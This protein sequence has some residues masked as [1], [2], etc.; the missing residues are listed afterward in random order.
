MT[1]NKYGCEN[2]RWDLSALYSSINCPELEAD[3]KTCES[4][5][6][7]IS[8]TCRGKVSELD[9]NGLYELI[10]RMENVSERLGKINSFAEL[11]FATQVT[12]PEAGA[13]LQKI[14]EFSSSVSRELLFF[15][16]EWT[17]VPDPQA[18]ALISDSRLARYRHFLSSLRRYK[19]HLLT[20]AE[21]RI[22]VEFNPVGTDS[23][24][25][26]FE[27]LLADQR[28]GQNG[29]TQEELLSDLYNPA[30]EIR[31][32]AAS[33]L[34]NGLKANGLVLTHVFNT[35]LATKMIDDRL[36]QYP[37]W[38][39]S[40]NLHNE[41]EDSI[42]NTLTETVIS[43]YDMVKRYY[44]L[45]QKLLGLDR[46]YDYDRYAPVKGLPT[47]KIDWLTCKEQV[48][49]AFG[50]FSGEMSGIAAHF[51]DENWIDAPV[52]PGK[53]GGAF[54]HPCVPSAHPYILVN[55][56]GDTR[57]VETVAHEL[58]HGVHQALA[59]QQGYFESHTP[60]TFAETASVFA[61]M[62]VFQSLLETVKEP[63]ARLAMLC[64]K[65]ESI[66]A[67]VFRQIAMNQFEDSLHTLRREKGELSQEE[68]TSQW[69]ATQN[70]MFQGSVDLTDDY[71]IW[72]SYIG[73][74][75][76][77]P[78]YV[79]A[80]AFGELLVLS[81]YDIYRNGFPE[82]EQRYLELLGAGGSRTPTQLMEPFGIDLNSKKFWENGLNYIEKMIAE[83]EKLAG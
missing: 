34:T 31:Q 23:W 72:W 37:G 40:M 58:G 2:V 27:K 35:I 60:L 77:A 10:V 4:E 83:A 17:K 80:Y 12:A 82:F 61:E 53:T 36:R 79:Y 11:N 29:R 26:L 9:V 52:V 48:L 13:F 14:S 41:L 75:L 43:R 3:M 55:Y 28:Y 64:S 69:L 49:S 65:I 78:G 57:D 51:F 44:R 38:L 33:D 25:K 18:D 7:Q 32:K 76:H 6:L 74:F 50:R 63:E 42:V 59:A 71:G 46:L 1:Q 22:L 70:A 20:E 62:L 66:F 19:P 39:S 54:A 16:I 21:E 24:N 73:H 30:R 8:D 15:D 67:T 47:D 56:T 45:K 81:L 68:I 5:A